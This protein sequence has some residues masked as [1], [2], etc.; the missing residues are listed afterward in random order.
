MWILSQD[1]MT[2]ITGSGTVLKVSQNDNGAAIVSVP[3]GAAGIE[4]VTI[5]RY[6]TLKEAQSAFISLFRSHRP[7]SEL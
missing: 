4:P 7:N 2:I 3:P 1:K 6:K 5:G